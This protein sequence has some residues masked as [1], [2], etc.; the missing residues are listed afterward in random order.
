MCVCGPEGI[1]LVI[2]ENNRM[3][4]TTSFVASKMIS[5]TCVPLMMVIPSV[6]GEYLIIKP[7]GISLCTRSFRLILQLNLLPTTFSLTLRFRKQI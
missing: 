3:L 2:Y 7:S 1:S 6:Q 4:I 5:M